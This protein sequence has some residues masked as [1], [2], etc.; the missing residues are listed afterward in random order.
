HSFD[1]P[2]TQPAVLSRPLNIFS[3]FPRETWE[4]IGK[5]N[6]TKRKVTVH[7][8]TT[9]RAQYNQNRPIATCSFGTTPNTWGLTNITWQNTINAAL[10]LY[11]F[12]VTTLLPGTKLTVI[13]NNHTFIKLIEH[14]QS[15]ELHKLDI[16]DKHEY[17]YI[18][19]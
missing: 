15:I 6:N 9:S 3:P 2:T 10:S 11:A 16:L 13:S 19:H 17:S 7:L 8:L 14:I 1:N 18:L 4:T 5:T 12:V